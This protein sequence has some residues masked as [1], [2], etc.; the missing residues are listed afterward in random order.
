M[1]AE[2]P[3]GGL[4]FNGKIGKKEAFSFIKPKEKKRKVH[5]D[6]IVLAFP[7]GVGDFYK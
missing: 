1:E 2:L 4:I 7:E 6:A 3:N 5:K